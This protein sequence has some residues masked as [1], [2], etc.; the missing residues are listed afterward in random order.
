MTKSLMENSVTKI[1]TAL[2]MLGIKASSHQIDLWL[3]HL[4]L[5]QK[6]NKAYNMTAITAFDEMLVKHLF[7]SLT[8]APFITGHSNAR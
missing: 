7:D 2:E 6:W 1:I 3:R 5:L 8:I 4:S